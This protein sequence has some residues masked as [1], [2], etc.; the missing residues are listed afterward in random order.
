MVA[1]AAMF[2]L[3]RREDRP[4]GLRAAGKNAISPERTTLLPSLH[5]RML[6]GDIPF[7]IRETRFRHS[8]A[9][10]DSLGWR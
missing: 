6:G 1:D 9:E 2:S 8:I 5:Y 7:T 10:L 4:E 3:V